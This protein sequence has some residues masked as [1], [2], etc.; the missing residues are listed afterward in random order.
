MK[1]VKLAIIYYSSTGTNYKLSKAA[2]EA[3]KDLGVKEIKLLRVEET[4][5]EEI[6]KTNE[7]WIKHFNATKDVPVASIDDLEWA[8]AIIF[9]APTRYGNLPSQFSSLMDSTGPL[10]QKGKLVDKVVSGM[11]S[12]GNPHG[13]QEGTL[14]ALYKSMM[15]WGA[16]IANPGYSDPVIFETGGNPYGFSTVGGSDLSD[17]DKQAIKAQVK[18]TV[19]IAAKIKA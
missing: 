7:D 6:M 8:D 1:D 11:T 3:A 17:K 15:H 14:L 13:G 5:P 10:W 19:G 2:E 12:A 4:V 9:S 18:R 16:V